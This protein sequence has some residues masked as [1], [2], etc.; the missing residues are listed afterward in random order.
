MGIASGEQELCVPM[1]WIVSLFNG[2]P[3]P[4]SAADVASGFAGAVEAAVADLHHSLSA[5]TSPVS[6][7]GA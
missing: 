5:R 6:A 4:S 1:E 2:E 7:D 3:T